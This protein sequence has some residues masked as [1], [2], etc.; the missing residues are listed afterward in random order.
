MWTPN[1]NQFA[2]SRNRGGYGWCSGSYF[3]ATTIKCGP[4]IKISLR[5][6]ETVVDVGGVVGRAEG[7]MQAVQ[8]SLT[9]N[10]RHCAV[11][12]EIAWSA[13]TPA[14]VT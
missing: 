2:C 14:G 4:Q 13:E 8:I 7:V 12:V 11:G 5:V 9:G 10:A 3:I 1:Q 6:A